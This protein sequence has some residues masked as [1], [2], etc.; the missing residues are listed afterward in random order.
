MGVILTGAVFQAD[1]RISREI[2][3]GFLSDIRG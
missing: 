1:G 3:L 2:A